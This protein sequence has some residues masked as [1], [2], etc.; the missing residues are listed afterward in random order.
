MLRGAVLLD[1]GAKELPRVRARLDEA[2]RP[3]EMARARIVVHDDGRAT[4]EVP[5]FT[6]ELARVAQAV[7]VATCVSVG[8]S[9]GLAWMIQRALPAGFLVGAGWAAFTIFL[10]RKR[11]H[12]IARP[13]LRSLAR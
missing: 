12:A 9:L 11:L 1:V 7:G 4:Y 2:Q 10:D 6:W 5:T 13:F 3:R 8:T